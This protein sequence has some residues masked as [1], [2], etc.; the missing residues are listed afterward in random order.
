MHA[1]SPRLMCNY[2]ATHCTEWRF[3][4]QYFFLATF[5]HQGDA[6]FSRDAPSLEA[7]KWK[8]IQWP[9]LLARAGFH[10][11]GKLTNYS[12]VLDCG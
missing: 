12:Y 8:E 1:D 6:G 11:Q 2:A 4:I 9:T 7:C 5:S 10:S 3:C